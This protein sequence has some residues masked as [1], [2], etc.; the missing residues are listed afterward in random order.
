MNRP[1]SSVDSAHV[2]HDAGAQAH[3]CFHC[4]LDIPPGTHHVLVIDGQPRE[5][6]CPGCLAVAQT[7]VDSGLDGYYRHRTATAGA[8]DI[9]GRALPDALVQELAL[10]DLASVQQAFVASLGETEREASLVIEGISCA[11]CTWLLE[12]HLQRQ[13]GVLGVSV[14]LS[15]HRMRLRWDTSSTSLS[16]LLGQIYR[17]GYQGHPYHPDKEQQLLER[18]KKRAIMRLG[19]AG[20]GMMQVMMYAIALYAGALQDMEPQFVSF[21]RWA[22]LIVATPVALYAALPFYQAALR[23]LR[24]RHLSMDVPVSIAVLGAYSASV[25]ATLTRSGEVYFDSVTMFTFFLLIGRY[26]EMQARHRTGRAGNALLNLLPNSAIR[27]VDGDELLVPAG[28]LRVGDRVLVKPGQS[29]PADGIIR[30]GHSSI[31]ESALTGEY[32]PIHHG[33]GDAVVGGTLNVENPI[34]LEVSQVGGDTQLSAIVRLLDRAQSEKP[35]TARLADRISSYFVAAVLLTAGF[36]GLIWWQLEPANAFWVT[37]SVLV[38]TCPCALSLATPTA[39]TTATG[40]LRQQGLLIT[41][42]HVLESLAKATHMVFDKTGTLTQGNL[43]LHSVITLGA[44]RDQA[45]RLAAALE[46]HSEHPIAKAFHP[47]VHRPADTLE[48]HLG[49]GLEGEIDGARYR[50]GTAEFAAALCPHQ[51][52]PALPDSQN[53]WLLLCSTTAPLAWFGLDDQLRPQAT[54]CIRSLQALGLQVELLSGDSSP[55]VQHV[56]RSL[57]IDQVHGGMSPDQKL[58]HIRALQRNGARVVMVGDGINDI[59]VL[60]GA[61]TSIAMGSATDLA[62]T[63]ADGVLM[64]GDLSRLVEGIVLARKTRSII[65][66]NLGWALLY[67]L[68]ALPLAASGLIAPYMAALG[69]SAS[70]LVVVGNAMRLARSKVKGER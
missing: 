51:P 63:C 28:E 50:I 23:D 54:D 34:E 55:A 38:V 64:S 60:A 13:A 9:A 20:V 22:S 41:R 35:A 16:T 1:L 39:L 14:N 15:N 66:Q 44:E 65:R 17:I 45:L 4:G 26:L 30:R 18:E 49:Q 56:S 8:L 2:A 53:Q 11:A 47:F 46:A 68:L 19:V 33:E 42:G 43:S 3:G 24:S 21:I 27:L 37:L 67:N 32:L 36:V 6:C 69:M 58:A 52:A 7:I 57:G 31:D 70:S 40:T 10:Y 5:L 62:K 25:W 61:Q 29:L 48:S 59:P 12:H